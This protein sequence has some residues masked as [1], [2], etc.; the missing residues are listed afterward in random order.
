ML[1]IRKRNGHKERE[2]LMHFALTKMEE[3]S[4][5]ICEDLKVNNFK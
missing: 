5:C 3:R 1:G 4:L 2:A